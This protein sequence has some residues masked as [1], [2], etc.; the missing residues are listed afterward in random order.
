MDDKNYNPDVEMETDGRIDGARDIMAG[1]RLI[2][3]LMKAKEIWKF[4]PSV[5][6]DT[7]N[8][9]ACILDEM[10]IRSGGTDG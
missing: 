9:I 2:S 10:K 3:N 8:L 5:C 6:R 7:D 4:S 1:A